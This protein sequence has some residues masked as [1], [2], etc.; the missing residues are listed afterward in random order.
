MPRKENLNV[1]LC[2]FAAK[3]LDIDVE[4]NIQMKGREVMKKKNA[5]NVQEMCKK[6]ARHVQEMCKKC[7]RH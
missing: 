1:Y 4:I 5:R 6:C 7:A 3:T 2:L